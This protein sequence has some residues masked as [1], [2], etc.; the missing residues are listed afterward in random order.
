MKRASEAF[1]LAR[2]EYIAGYD[3]KQTRIF[4]TLA[5]VSK[6]F[7]ISFSTLQKKQLVKDGLRNVKIFSNHE[8]NLTSGRILKA[9]TPN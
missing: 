7:E 6:E 9:N 1:N 8:K 4:P 2:D 5:L 3:D